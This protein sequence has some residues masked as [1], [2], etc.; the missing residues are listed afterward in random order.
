MCT[1]FTFSPD[2]RLRL[3]HSQPVRGLPFQR[4]L[5][6]HATHSP[7]QHL[8]QPLSASTTSPRRWRGDARHAVRWWRTWYS[9]SLSSSSFLF[10]ALRA[11]ASRI[12]SSISLVVE[13]RRLDMGRSVALIMRLSMEPCGLR[14]SST[15]CE[16]RQ[17]A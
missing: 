12:R 6:V 9:L 10:L 15:S 11:L 13:S 8:Q 5:A 3:W 1:V 16:E 2:E 4:G 14:R 17:G 7:Q